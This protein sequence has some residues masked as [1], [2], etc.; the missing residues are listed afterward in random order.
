VTLIDERP[1]RTTLLGAPTRVLIPESPHR[2]TRRRLV[3]V[4]ALL[5]VVLG[6]SLVVSAGG[7]NSSRGSSAV[8]SAS[9]RRVAALAPACTLANDITLSQNHQLNMSSAWWDVTFVNH[10][11]TACSLRGVPLLQ[12]VR[13]ARHVALGQP[14]RVVSS[15]VTRPE[16]LGLAARGGTAIVAVTS[17]EP[18][19]MGS[20]CGGAGAETGMTLTFSHRTFYVAIAHVTPSTDADYFGV[21]LHFTRLAYHGDVSI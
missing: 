1:A 8:S 14:S 9:A 6:A 16:S 4:G 2:A 5:T 20:R 7:E 19:M 3:V 15:N 18:A 12:F 21:C 13:G 17:T 11:A 10:S